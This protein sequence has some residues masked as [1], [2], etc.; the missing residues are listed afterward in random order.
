M[1]HIRSYDIAMSDILRMAVVARRL[2]PDGE[3]LEVGVKQVG[4]KR[5]HSYP[6]ERMKLGDFFFVPLNGNKYGALQV[7]FRQA[8]A[9]RDWE[10]AIV[11]VPHNGADHL[12]VCL[13]LTGVRALKEKAQQ[14]HGIPMSSS[15]GQWSKARKCRH[16]A[17][18]VARRGRSKSTGARGGARPTEAPPGPPDTPGDAPPVHGEV[19]ATLSPTY[20]REA[21][22]RERLKQLGVG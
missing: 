12:R 6:W 14:Y 17:G 4:T 16:Q 1:T 5:M 18:K 3:L 9:R 11:T 10:L 22:M 20:D 21:V 7:R 15:D 19:D 8:A 2:N 13:T